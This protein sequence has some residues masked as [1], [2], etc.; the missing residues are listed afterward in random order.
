M[1]IVAGVLIGLVAG[2]AGA[3]AGIGGGVI[4]V[5]SMVFFLGLPQTTAQGTSLMAMLFTTVAGTWVN[6]SN[7]RVDLA[8]AFWIGLGGAAAAQ[9]GKEAALAIDPD[10]LQR[11]FGVFVL[12]MGLRMARRGWK[13]IA[14]RTE[15]G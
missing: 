6:V 10:L 12:I 8:Q 2:F 13:G 3:V 5:P 4:M 7:R 1:E 9:V 14:R 11:L 15:E